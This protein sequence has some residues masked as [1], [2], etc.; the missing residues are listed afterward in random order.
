MENCTRPAGSR[1]GKRPSAA[2]ARAPGR[3]F[4]RRP[5]LR[6]VIP[7]HPPCQQG[8]QCHDQRSGAWSTARRCS[9]T[10]HDLGP[11]DYL[12]L[13]FPGARLTG[14]GLAVLVDLV[15]R[16]IIRVLDLRFIKVEADG[17]FVALDIADLDSDGTLDLAIFEGAASGLL[18]EDDLNDAAGLVTP[19]NALG[20]LVYENTWA[21]PFVT[22]MRHAGAEVITSGRLTVDAIDAVLDALESADS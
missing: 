13:E 14:E 9:M 20:L 19:G 7:P 1:R 15:D 5:T 18:G 22:A 4:S 17:S 8:G 12:A 16:G 11:I 6:G 10:E 2:A 21:G 3:A